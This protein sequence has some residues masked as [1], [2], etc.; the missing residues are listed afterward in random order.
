MEPVHNKIFLLFTDNMW[1]GFALLSPWRPAHAVRLR[2]VSPSFL[3]GQADV[4]NIFMRSALPVEG[5]ASTAVDFRKYAA[6]PT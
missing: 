5:C 3:P 2:P 6:W 1:R 4:G